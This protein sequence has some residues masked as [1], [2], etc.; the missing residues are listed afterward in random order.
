MNSTGEALPGT[1]KMKRGEVGLRVAGS[2]LAI[3]SR[4]PISHS[5]LRAYG[6][7]SCAGIDCLSNKGIVLA[8]VL[9]PGVP[10][11]VDIYNTHLNSSGASRAPEQRRDAAHERQALEASEFINKTHDDANPVILGGDFN[12]RNSDERWSQFQR[13]QKLALVHQVC[14]SGFGDCDVRM[15]WDGDEPWMD[16]QDLQFFWS[17]ESVSIRPIRVET[18]FDGSPSSPALSDHDGLKVTYELRWRGAVK[19]ASC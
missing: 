10:R 14:A 5:D 3:A 2:G 16:T 12:M 8:R 15:S 6:K 1:A 4:F 9:I 19:P 18:M 11:P 13:Y 7:K 17:G